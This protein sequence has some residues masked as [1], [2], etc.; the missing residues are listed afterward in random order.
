M[1]WERAREKN[2]QEL[3]LFL[4]PLEA[5][6]VNFTSRLLKNGK[7]ALPLKREAQIFLLRTSETSEESQIAAAVLVTFRGLLVPVHNPQLRMS[8][9][10]IKEGMQHFYRYCEKIYCIIGLSETVRF[11]T[12]AVKE[13]VDTQIDY[14]LMKREAERPLPKSSLP[15][16]LQIRK[17]N[18]KYIQGVY[19]LEKDYQHEEVLVHPERFNSMAHLLHFRRQAKNQHILFASSGKQPIG[20]AGTNAIGINYVQIGGVFTDK[21][22]RGKGIAKALM[23]RLLQDIHHSG[24]GAVLF[25]RKTNNPAVQLYLNIGFEIIG[26][27]H[28]TYTR[29]F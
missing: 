3:I 6:S 22:H 28:I 18:E 7:L 1:Y 17:L 4:Q 19:Q 16:G 25:V 8:I 10:I 15:A 14:Y 20:K 13:S 23:L 27:Y 2:L 5:A 11:Y 24:R 29:Y 21:E 12:H 9:E 26:E